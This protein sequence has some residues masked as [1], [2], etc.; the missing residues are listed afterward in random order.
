MVTLQEGSADTSWIDVQFLKEATEQLVECR[1]VLKQ[2][3]VLAY[4]LPTDDKNGRKERF[5]HHQEM[6]EKFT[7][8]LSELSEMS[9]EKMDRGDVVNMTRVVD[10]FVKNIVKYVEDGEDED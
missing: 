8:R 1:R 2:T 4:Y 5:E 10:R 6:L 3:Y 7:E 9:L